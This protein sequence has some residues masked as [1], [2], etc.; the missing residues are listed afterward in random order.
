MRQ[1]AIVIVTFCIVAIF[2]YA[3]WAQIAGE[4]E[5]RVNKIIK[6]PPRDDP[7]TLNSK[8]EFEYRYGGGL[9]PARFLVANGFSPASISPDTPEHEFGEK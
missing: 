1:R 3:G 2:P 5:V 8:F 9:P 4:W 6:K 7:D